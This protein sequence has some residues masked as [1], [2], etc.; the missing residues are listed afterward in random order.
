MKR[1]QKI[2]RTLSA[3]ETCTPDWHDRYDAMLES[4]SHQMPSGSGFDSGCTISTDSTPEKIIIETAYHHMNENGY[5][6]EWTNHKVI[7]TPSLAFSF[8]IKVTGRD[9]NNIKDYII[10][11]FSAWMV[12][13]A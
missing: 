9:R 8:N 12:E 4:I 5:Y 13:E 3:M 10:D 7:I 6:T 1:Y 11:V 2:A